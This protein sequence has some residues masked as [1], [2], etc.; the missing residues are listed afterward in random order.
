[1]GNRDSLL[2]VDIF[3]LSGD[4]RTSSVGALNPGGTK[5]SRVKNGPACFNFAS[6]S[7]YWG[8]E[9]PGASINMAAV[10]EF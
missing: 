7:I 1:M 6:C 2:L 8:L 5:K 3:F 9:V 10:P 4:A